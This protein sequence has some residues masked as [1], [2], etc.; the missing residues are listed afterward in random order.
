MLSYTFK[1]VFDI[2]GDKPDK[3]I[4]IV[5]NKSA[6]AKRGRKAKQPIVNKI[7]DSKSESAVCENESNESD[8]DS[9]I[10]MISEGTKFEN[11]TY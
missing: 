7:D 9:K 3:E 8:L 10:N 11:F 5:T 2:S 1:D 6:K 4:L